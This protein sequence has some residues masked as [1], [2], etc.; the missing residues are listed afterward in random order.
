MLSGSSL[1]QLEI[2]FQFTWKLDSY[3]SL[4]KKCLTSQSLTTSTGQCNRVLEHRLATEHCKWSENMDWGTCNFN[5]ALPRGLATRQC[6]MVL[7][8]GLA[9]VQCSTT[10]QHGLAT[11][12]L[13][14]VL[15]PGLAAE[16]CE[17]LFL[18]KL[19]APAAPNG[20][21]NCRVPQSSTP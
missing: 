19:T 3:L 16:P 2:L 18:F 17:I 12:P 10:V 20:F 13:N 21:R 4:L 8:R 9:T 11:G 15:Q 14:V 5:V 6:N 1:Q 7:A